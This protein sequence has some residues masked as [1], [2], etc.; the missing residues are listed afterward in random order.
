MKGMKQNKQPS[1]KDRIR[2]LETLTQNLQMAV[3][4][5]QMMVKHLTNQIQTFQQDLGNTMGMLNDF[6]YRTL[7][8]LELGD[9]DKAKVDEIADGYKLVD[10]N[11]ASAKEDGIKGYINDDDGVV[12]EESIVIL[13]SKTPDLEE[14][15]GIFRSKFPMSECLTPDLREQLLGSKVNDTFVADIN[16]VNHEITILGLRKIEVQEAEVETTGEE[17]SGE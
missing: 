2:E 17:T 5:S 1:T 8:M 4:M 14:D 11:N 13:T 12:N 3:Q 15:Q 7:A 16:G 10:F 6:Q 9:F